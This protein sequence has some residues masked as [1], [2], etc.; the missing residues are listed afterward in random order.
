MGLAHPPNYCEHAS[1]EVE[2][3]GDTFAVSLPGTSYQV[4]FRLSPDEP[5]LIQSANLSVDKEAPMSHKD[6]E[7]MAW[8]AAQAKAKELGW[9]SNWMQSVGFGR[10]PSLF[11]AAPHLMEL[12]EPFRF[13][14]TWRIRH[15]SYRRRRGKLTRRIP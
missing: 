7:A 11:G 10:T 14:R 3:N 12:Q 8:E 15:K 5:R 4:L 9:L 6:F 13:A 2:V 1:V